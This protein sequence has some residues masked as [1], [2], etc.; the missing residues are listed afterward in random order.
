MFGAVADFFKAIP[1]LRLWLLFEGDIGKSY[2]GIHMPSLVHIMGQIDSVHLP[3]G[4]AEPL[5]GI[6]S[7]TKL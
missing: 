5:I 2:D 7:Q 4:V 6:V 3:G 1:H